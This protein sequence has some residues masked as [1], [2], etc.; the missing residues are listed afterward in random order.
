MTDL[1]GGPVEK[2]LA[3][4]IL[5]DIAAGR[6]TESFK[7]RFPK[8]ATQI[9]QALTTTGRATG[10]TAAQESGARLSDA[11]VV[12]QLEGGLLGYYN[13]RPK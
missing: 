2:A 1:N 7:Q 11:P 5:D 4:Q 10:R 8:L 9:Q 12:E 6:I 3:E 13:T